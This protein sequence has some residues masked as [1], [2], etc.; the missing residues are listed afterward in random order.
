M[1]LVCDD[2]LRPL[3]PILVEEITPTPE[4]GSAQLLRPVAQSIS[5][6]FPGAHVLCA[7]ARRGALVATVEDYA[8]RAVIE[9]AFDC[10]P[11]IGVHLITLLGS[12]DLH[13]QQAA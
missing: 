3:Q 5:Q 1:I 6:A 10:L 4:P 2:S 12:R 11:V 8:W 13:A 9:E 7:V